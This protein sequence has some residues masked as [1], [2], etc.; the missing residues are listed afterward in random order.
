[1]AG[2]RIERA[3]K[4]LM[5]NRLEDVLQTQ[6]DLE[7]KIKQ[8]QRETQVEEYQKFWNELKLKNGELMKT[9][10]RYMVSKCNR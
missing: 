2:I 1:M 10:S 8:F 7:Q 3:D 9:V 4:N 6:K 5:R